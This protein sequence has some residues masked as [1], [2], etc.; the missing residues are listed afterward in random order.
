MN[1]TRALAA[2]LAIEPR[3]PDQ[4]LP[5]VTLL[6]GIAAHSVLGS[7]LRLKWPNDVVTTAGDKVA[8]L[9]TERTDQLVVIGLGVNL[10]W[11]NAPEGMGAVYRL[12]PGPE[13]GRQV[14]GR[15]ADSVLARIV[16]GPEAWNPAEYESISATIGS[17]VTW[18]GGG[19]ASAVA[20][21]P[22][23]G[24]IVDDGAHRSVL[25]S[26]R[27]EQVRTTTLPD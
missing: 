23:G 4:R 17:T 12:D 15:W 16:A 14:A 8:G 9:L 25:R 5:L 10:Y 1:A 11:P 6:A 7:E 24:L 26:G 19:P 18:D 21:D 2:S 13:A 22:N 27:V 3:W 20:L